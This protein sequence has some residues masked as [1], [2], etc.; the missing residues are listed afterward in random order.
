[1][2]R[3]ELPVFPKMKKNPHKSEKVPSLM[4]YYKIPRLEAALSPSRDPTSPLDLF[5]KN[6]WLKN[7]MVRGELPVFPKVKKNPHK[8]EKVRSLM[9]YYKIPRLEVVLSPSRDPRS[10]LDLFKKTI[11]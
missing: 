4:P 1:M 6:S 10:L 7:I 9:T 8:S 5:K 3:G 2:V 11:G